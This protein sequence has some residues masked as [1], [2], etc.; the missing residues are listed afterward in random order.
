MRTAWRVFTVHPDGVLRWDSDVYVGAARY[1][2]VVLWHYAFARHWFKVNLTT[3]VTGRIV[4]TGGDE[5]G[6][7]SRSTVISPLRCAARMTRC[8]PLTYSLTCWYPRMASPARCATWLSSPRRAA[9]GWSCPVRRAGPSGGLAEL[10]GLERRGDL[11]AFLSRTCLA[12]YYAH[13]RGAAAVTPEHLLHGVLRDLDDAYGAQLGRRGRK[14]LTQLGW[15]IGPVNPASALLQVR[16]VDT[17]R[18][19]TELE[20]MSS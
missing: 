11:L 3:S 18:L 17:I 14:H 16:D 1:G 5:P 15:T 9:T 4:E 10:T 13:R 2:D 19:R 12:S 7:R 20:C 8:S 6:R